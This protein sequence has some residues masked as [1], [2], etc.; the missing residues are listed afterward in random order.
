MLLLTVML[1]IAVGIAVVLL[2]RSARLQPRL[3]SL[4]TF[5]EKEV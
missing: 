4:A 5:V 2:C 3:L 1:L